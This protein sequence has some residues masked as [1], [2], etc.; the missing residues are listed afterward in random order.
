MFQF[1]GF[2]YFFFNFVLNIPNGYMKFFLKNIYHM[3]CWKKIF[4]D[5]FNF[6]RPSKST[7]IKISK[8][9]KKFLK[10]FEKFGTFVDYDGRLKLTISGNMKDIVTKSFGE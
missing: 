3:K 1:T 10:N 5:I 7:K 6:K 8:F 2:G 4:G 9:F